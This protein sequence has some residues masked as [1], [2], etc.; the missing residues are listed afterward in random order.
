MQKEQVFNSEYLTSHG[1]NLQAA[2]NIVDLPASIIEKTQAYSQLLMIAHGGRK[3]WEVLQE[4]AISS[5]N[6]IDDFSQ[7]IVQQYF[8]SELPQHKFKIVYPSPNAIGLTKLGA[9]AGW[10]HESPFRIGVNK[11]WG[12]WFA[13]RVVVLADT[14]F[15]PHKNI[16]TQSPCLSCV[17]KSCISACP[18]DAL[19]SGSL[20]LNSCID[21]RKKT[22]SLCKNTCLSRVSCPVATQHRYTEEQVNYH[23]SVS[24]ETIDRYY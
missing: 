15:E 7:Q 24:M 19:K 8:K 14:D 16:E 13:Y 18:A 2:F 21:Y 3:M 20:S 1:L 23:Y 10:H 4:H 6:P 22:A 12:S 9:L 5:A 17:E 11:T